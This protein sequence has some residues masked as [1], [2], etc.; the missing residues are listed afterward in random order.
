MNHLFDSPIFGMIVTHSAVYARATY[1][2]G[3][4]LAFYNKLREA[5]EDGGDEILKYQI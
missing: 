5:S 2:P 3:M 1:I 4:Q